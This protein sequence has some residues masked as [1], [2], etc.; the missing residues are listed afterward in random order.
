MEA[1]RRRRDLEELDALGA[2]ELAAVAE[3]GAA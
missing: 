1:A 2:G 3:A